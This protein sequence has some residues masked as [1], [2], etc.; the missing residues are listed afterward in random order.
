MAIQYDLRRD[1]AGWSVFDRWTGEIVVIA[2]ALQTGLP[3]RD[4]QALIARLHRR[5]D[6]GDRSLLQ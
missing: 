1:P 6:D 3:W 4:A 5:R 2:G